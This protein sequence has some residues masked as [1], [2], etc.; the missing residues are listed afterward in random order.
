MISINLEDPTK[1]MN[2]NIKF[3]KEIFRNKIIINK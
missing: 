3:F 2:G 1:L